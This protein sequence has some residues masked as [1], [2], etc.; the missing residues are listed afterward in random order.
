MLLKLILD[1]IC[2]HK[3]NLVLYLNRILNIEE[4][5][6]LEWLKTV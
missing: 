6:E 2:Y 1:L 5:A 4:N 3:V